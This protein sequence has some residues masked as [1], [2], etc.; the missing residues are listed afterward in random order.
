MYTEW[1]AAPGW[2]AFVFGITVLMEDDGDSCISSPAGKVFVQSLLGKW[3]LFLM[4]S[5]NGLGCL[6]EMPGEEERPLCVKPASVSKEG[7][8]GV[9]GELPRE[10]PH[11]VRES[12][13]VPL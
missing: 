7:P 9:A 3:L 6:A 11:P 8:G 1:V 5:L 10:L 12:D 13:P 4:D 2:V